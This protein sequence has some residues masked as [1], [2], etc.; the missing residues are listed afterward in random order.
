MKHE[1]IKHLKEAAV[2]EARL[3]LS[4]LYTRCEEGTRNLQGLQELLPLS[5]HSLYKP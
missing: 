3:Y 4:E 1:K 5:V 2:A